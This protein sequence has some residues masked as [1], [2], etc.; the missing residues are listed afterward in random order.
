MT[1]FY[2]NENGAENAALWAVEQAYP[3]SSTYQGCDRIQS[4]H[5]H[6]TPK[7]HKARETAWKRDIRR[8][9]PM[10][11]PTGSVPKPWG[12]VEIVVEK[13]RLSY[14]SKD[15]DCVKTR[16]CFLQ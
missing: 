11:T 2:M 4:W 12:G 10:Y 8:S 16:S 13:Q 6:L 9:S 7:T 15:P 3:F 1:F 14:A 5:F